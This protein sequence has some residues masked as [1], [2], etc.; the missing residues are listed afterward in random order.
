M[1]AENLRRGIFTE[2][3]IFVLVLGLCPSLAVST[4]LTNGIG[5]GLAATFVLACSNVIISI[6]KNFIPDKVRIPCYIVV[7]AAFVTIVQL[8]LKAYLPALDKQLGIFV[9]L[10]VVNCIILGRAEAYA[11]K[12]NAVK[13]LVDG[14]AIGI[15][16]TFSLAILSIIRE[17]I[18]SNKLL[19][20]KVFPGFEPMT[21]FI[22]A[23][24][25]FFTI[26]LVMI[27]IRYSNSRKKA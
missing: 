1:I 20:L 15:G 4:S 16:F 11:S 7:I 8:L 22:L 10:I 27:F 12:N 18:G 19:G 26:A 13:S 9:P 24:G 14:I 17:V 3:P 2:N 23:P 25:G 21:I 5:M 6:I